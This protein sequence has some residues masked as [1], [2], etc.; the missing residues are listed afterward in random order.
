MLLSETLR[1]PQ[2]WRTFAIQ[3]LIFFATLLLISYGMRSTEEGFNWIM[4]SD[5]LP[6]IEKMVKVLNAAKSQVSQ[7]P[8]AMM[9]IA[10]ILKEGLAKKVAVLRANPKSESLQQ[11]AK[12]LSQAIE[13]YN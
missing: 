2:F 4:Q 12:L 5:D 9:A 6:A 11:Q 10:S 3:T 7:N 1:K 13:A 8:Q